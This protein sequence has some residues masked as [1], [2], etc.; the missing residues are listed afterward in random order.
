MK[1]LLIILAISLSSVGCALT[2]PPVIDASIFLKEKPFVDARLLERCP[3]DL[4]SLPETEAV[5]L[6]ATILAFRSS[7]NTY[8]ECSKKHDSLRTWVC[9]LVKLE[10]CPE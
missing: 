7:K 2:Q 8:S 5:E 10:P 6:K 3:K 9:D 4:A 1:N